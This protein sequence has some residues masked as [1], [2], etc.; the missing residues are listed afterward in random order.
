MAQIPIIDYSNQYGGAVDASRSIGAGLDQ[1]FGIRD[2][3]QKEEEDRARKEAE[4]NRPL[5]P[6]ISQIIQKYHGLVQ[7]GQMTGAQAAQAANQ[8]AQP[9]QGGGLSAGAPPADAAPA[10]APQIVDHSPTLSPDP[11]G[12]LPGGAPAGDRSVQVPVPPAAGQ[13][14]GHTINMHFHAPGSLGDLQSAGAPPPT[15][16]PAA[17]PQPAPQSIA[18]PSY[19]PFTKRDLPALEI[20]GRMK[21]ER[22]YAAE[23]AAKGG[24]Q[25][26]V[27]NINAGAKIKV[28][29]EGNTSREKVA[30]EGNTSKEKMAGE[31]NATDLE[32]QRMSDDTRLEM[33]KIAAAAKRAVAAAHG[34]T[35]KVQAD[36]LKSVDHALASLYAARSRE[37][38]P[39]QKKYYEEQIVDLTGERERIAHDVERAQ[40]AAPKPGSSPPPNFTFPGGKKFYVAP[41][42]EAAAKKKGGVPL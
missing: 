39:S 30:G 6:M 5:H 32:R 17:R 11:A 31:K 35:A 12:D 2:A 28:G 42:Q 37:I 15:P 3:R 27:A 9:Y 21:P 38:D 40:A 29:E 22:D 10:E 19:P 1:G 18:S 33:A 41:G 4:L 14:G 16:A 23:I 8:E 13:M 26:N 20:A 24:F 7:S 25:T 36:A 34:G